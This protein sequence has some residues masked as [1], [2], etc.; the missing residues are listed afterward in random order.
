MSDLIDIAAVSYRESAN[1]I[2]GLANTEKIQIM[3]MFYWLE[4]AISNVHRNQILPTNWNYITYSHMRFYTTLL[5]LTSGKQISSMRFLE[6][7]CGL[8]TKLYIASKWLGFGT[9]DGVE[10]NPT[11]AEIARDMLSGKGN[12]FCLD[13]R[14][15]RD[16]DK[17]DFIYSYGE[18]REILAE[19]EIKKIVMNA[20]KKG[21]FLLTAQMNAEI[22]LWQK[23]E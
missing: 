20:M 11:Y 4:C 16:Y 7:G 17:Y 12:V 13:V 1:D 21:A 10:I 9:S 8:G 2:D 22:T 6:M 23:T 5:H 14:S 3:E 18:V 19:K 15:F